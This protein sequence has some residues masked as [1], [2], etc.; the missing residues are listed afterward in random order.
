M[1]TK[2]QNIVFKVFSIV[3]K[4]CPYFHFSICMSSKSRV[5]VLEITITTNKNVRNNSD[6]GSEFQKNILF[7]V[8][9]SISRD[10]VTLSVRQRVGSH[11]QRSFLVCVSP[12]CLRNVSETKMSL[13]MI[14]AD[15]KKKSFSKILL[16]LIINFI[17]TNF[18]RVPVP[19]VAMVLLTAAGRKFWGFWDPKMW[20]LN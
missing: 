20:F 14:F 17:L 9:R 8:V 11:W 16:T 19:N 1:K 18:R 15:S 5:D 2:H 3:F 4:Y 13:K 10:T 12:R 6:G 7:D